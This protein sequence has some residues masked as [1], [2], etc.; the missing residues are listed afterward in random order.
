MRNTGTKIQTSNSVKL[1]PIT[2]KQIKLPPV[3]NTS[4][5]PPPYQDPI[6]DMLVRVA[7]PIS[8]HKLVQ[9]KA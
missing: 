2:T 6:E 8:K 9:M 3:R 1:I 5:S 4:N 7:S